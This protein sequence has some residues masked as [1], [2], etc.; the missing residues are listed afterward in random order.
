MNCNICCKLA[1]NASE[2]IEPR[3][4]K[5]MCSYCIKNVNSK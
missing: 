1:I 5:M 2:C 3:C 4:G